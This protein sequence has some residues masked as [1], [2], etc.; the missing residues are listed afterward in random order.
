MQRTLQRRTARQHTNGHAG[1]VPR[2]TGV[3]N[4]VEVSLRP[5]TKEFPLEARERLGVAVQRARE[6]A[7]YNSRP[8]FQALLQNVGLTSLVKLETGKPVG[9]SIYE[10]VARKLPNWDEE[11]PVTILGGGPIPPTSGP[12]FG[13]LDVSDMDDEP[14]PEPEQPQPSLIEQLEGLEQELQELAAEEQRLA[15][16]RENVLRRV[17]ELLGQGIGAADERRAG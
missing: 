10:E 12:I 11:S 13:N 14:E 4:H 17:A 7:G 16:R 5:S 15:E 6:A 8:A 3:R 1:Q 9:A 2:C